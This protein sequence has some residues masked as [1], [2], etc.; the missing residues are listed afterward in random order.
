[1]KTACIS[2]SRFLSTHYGLFHR[3]RRSGRIRGIGITHDFIMAL[4]RLKT[5]LNA[6]EDHVVFDSAAILVNLIVQVF[7]VS[8]ER[9][10][11]T[12]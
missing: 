3:S 11:S 12:F 7:K 6:I 1:M 9:F 10:F 2:A 5:V 8:T 4:D